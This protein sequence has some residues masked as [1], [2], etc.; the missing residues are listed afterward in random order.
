M[1]K[2]AQRVNSMKGSAARA[3]LN[4]TRK[5]GV[6]SFAGGLPAPELFP[7]EEYAKVAQSVIQDNGSDALQYGPTLGYI[8]L[9]TKIAERMQ[10]SG[11][12]TRMEEVMVT[13]GSQQGLEFMAKLFIDPGDIIVCESPSY[14]GAMTAFSSYEPRYIDIRTDD[15]GMDMEELEK[16]FDMPYMGTDRCDD[17]TRNYLREN[18][19]KAK[20]GD[21][22]GFRECIE[23]NYE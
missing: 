22:S 19:D 23:L 11:V 6:I 16:A 2:F 15:D 4:I 9:R 13:S 18:I 20:L 21:P 14:L 7:V 8:P 5:P 1:L 17:A 3:M 12:Q 10:K